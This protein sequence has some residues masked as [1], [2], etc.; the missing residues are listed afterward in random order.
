LRKRLSIQEYTDGILSGNRKLLGRAITLI[1]SEL[2][3]DQALA[4]EIVEKCLPYSAN[5]FRI[6]ISGAPGCGKSTF[7]EN[8]GLLLIKHGHKLAVL[9]VDPSSTISKGSILGDKTR[10]AELSMHPNAFIR[11]SPSGAMYG[12]I[13][14][15]TRE[16]IILC[17]AAGFDRIIIETVGVGQSEVIVGTMVDFFMVLMLA[18]AGDDIQGIK[19][20]I[21]E[22]ADALI[23]TKADGE[24]AQNVNAKAQE[25]KRAL[26]LF[27]Q[28]E[29][30]WKPE[31]LT[32]SALLQK[33]LDEI[34]ILLNLFLDFTKS[35]KS[36]TKN[37]L[38]QQLEWLHQTVEHQLK[39]LFYQHPT[40]KA[41][42]SET[43]A[44]I[45]LNEITP[46]KASQQLLDVFLQH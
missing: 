20:G 1:E 41:A 22:M 21:I 19:R 42:I 28:K 13:N 11:P 35:N 44:K 16:T 24:Y 17:E 25:F 29:N 2:E 32:C 10:M 8:F 23:F 30:G 4:Q 46:Y 27:P 15:M 36:F 33:G 26:E 34:I 6:G 38:N 5:S 43:V 31:V 45:K 40:V 12:G 7:I 18:G 37:R 9:A 39:Q 3:S 14:R